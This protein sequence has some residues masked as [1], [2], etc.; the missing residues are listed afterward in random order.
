MTFPRLRRSVLYLPASNPRA[1]EKARSLAC[2]AVILDLEDSVAPEVKAEARQQL[3]QA[4]AAG[5]F[6]KRELVVRIN[7]LSTP[8]G[9]EDIAMAAS[10]PADAIL[11][12][13]VNSSADVAEGR[14]I[15]GGKRL[16]AMVETPMSVM[17]LDDIAG[18]QDLSAL[19]M[20]TNDLAKD[21][22]ARPGP[23]R[24]PFLGFLASAVAAARAH[25]IA[26]LDGV[27]NG[28][29]DTDG[30]IR[31]CAQA[32]AF[33]FDGKTLIH[34]KQINGCNAAF[35]PSEEELD[36]ARQVV[37]AFELPESRDR[38]A[39]RVAGRLVERLHLDQAR[40]TLARQA[41]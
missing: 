38:G 16:W 19:V 20:G 21:M 8:W 3:S 11:L 22:N 12:P 24:L 25:G 31:E 30:F 26:V 4:L 27:F 14:K 37:E 28:I 18:A 23:D 6:G 17:R 36:W 33:G 7:A 2:D 13:K 5:G 39:I 15:S 10:S 41:G 1:I 34:P 35:S 29:D 32:A 9:A 40:L